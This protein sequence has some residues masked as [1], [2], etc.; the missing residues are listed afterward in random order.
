MILPL[1]YLWRHFTQV[2]NTRSWLR[3]QLCGLRAPEYPSLSPTSSKPGRFWKNAT[4]TQCPYVTSRLFDAWRRFTTDRAGNW[5][6]N[7]TPKRGKCKQKSGHFKDRPSDVL[8]TTRFIEW[9]CLVVKHNT[10]YVGG[11]VWNLRKDT[12]GLSTPDSAFLS[13]KLPFW[14]PNIPRF[15][16]S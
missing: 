1:P 6:S 8:K 10:L 7:V 5:F 16:T 13:R 9:I 12:Y 14:A 4:D 2:T 11:I 15:S 3:M